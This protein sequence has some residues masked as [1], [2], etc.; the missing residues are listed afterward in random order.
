MTPVIGTNGQVSNVDSFMA[1]LAIDFSPTERVQL[2][3]G[4]G[5][6]YNKGQKD[7]D[8]KNSFYQFTFRPRSHWH[9]KFT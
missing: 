6:L 1:M 5:Y 3:A 2:E 7:K 8:L 4:G 9:R